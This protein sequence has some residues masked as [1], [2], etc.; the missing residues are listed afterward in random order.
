MNS[1]LSPAAM[2]LSV[3]LLECVR[4]L[5]SMPNTDPE[6]LAG[7]M[8]REMDLASALA[9]A[10][11]LLGLL[12]S[13]YRVQQ[14]PTECDSGIEPLQ[15]Q[16]CARCSLPIETGESYIS[17]ARLQMVGGMA[18]LPVQTEHDDLLLFCEH[19]A[20]AIDKDSVS[21]RVTDKCGENYFGG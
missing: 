6:V 1:T 11:T 19:C 3:R 12:K 13:Q 2:P 8:I 7:M 15:G 17:F 18:E 5:S 4:R 9:A 20:G 14:Q 16:E 21:L 10:D